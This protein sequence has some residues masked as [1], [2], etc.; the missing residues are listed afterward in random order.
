MM[1]TPN[2]LLISAPAG[3]IVIH[4]TGDWPAASVQI[5]IVPSS[6]K[7][8]ASVIQQID[9]EWERVARSGITL[10]DGPM[11]RLESFHASAGALTLSLSETTYRIFVGTHLY[12][13]ELA[14]VHG[15]SILANS[16]GV[17]VLVRTADGWLLL[18]RRNET[19]VYYAGRLHPFAGALEPIDESNPFVAARRELHEEAGL[20]ESDMTALRCVAL[21]EDHQ[22][23]Q[24]ELIMRADTP[25][26]RA[27][28]EGQLDR[29]EHHD[30]VAIEAAA[31]PLC[32][33]LH[34]PN[35]TPVALGG[36]LTWGRSEWGDSWLQNGVAELR[37]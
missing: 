9:A 2:S 31:Q 28:I 23:R 12:H 16:I 32:A 15:P 26:S 11:C 24:A 18:G 14:D 37:C 3:R 33:A 21:V 27:Q 1:M 20:I 8:P 29:E 10:F 35:L 5:Q 7:A 13:T 19:V 34:N 36:L 4:A 22:L 17:S 6:W 25:L 30:L